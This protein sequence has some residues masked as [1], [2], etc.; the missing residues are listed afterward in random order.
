MY[1]AWYNVIMKSGCAL[2]LGMTDTD[3]FLFKVSDK[4]K[5]MDY[6]DSHMD[7]SNYLPSNPK[8]DMI[9]LL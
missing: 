1:K 2:D 8:F 7:Y 9:S 5:F 6:F 3:S 4:Q